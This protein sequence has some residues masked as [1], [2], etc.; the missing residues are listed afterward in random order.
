MRTPKSVL[1]KEINI[2][3]YGN[4]LI[5]T[6]L[7]FLSFWADA[8]ET[9]YTISALLALIGIIMLETFFQARKTQPMFWSILKWTI[10]YFII[11]QTSIQLGKNMPAIF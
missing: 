10:L 2:T 5:S 8:V 1:E 11:I 9:N 4:I 6:I 7:I 3:T